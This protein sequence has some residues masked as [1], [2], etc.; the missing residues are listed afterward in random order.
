[1]SP[2]VRSS[3][4]EPRGRMTATNNPARPSRCS[5]MRLTESPPLPRAKRKPPATIARRQAGRLLEGCLCGT[6][7]CLVTSIFG[8]G[9]IVLGRS[10][11]Q[12]RPEDP[13]PVCRRQELAHNV[14]QRRKESFGPRHGVTANMRVLKMFSDHIEDRIQLPLLARQRLSRC[15]RAPQ[16]LVGTPLQSSSILFQG[17][18]RSG[19]GKRLLDV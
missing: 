2:R 7:G 4:G 19:V 12:P 10:L 8:L 6:E 13:F 17:I 9:L 3:P 16:K 15:E 14:L 1:M 11:A 5:L 18:D